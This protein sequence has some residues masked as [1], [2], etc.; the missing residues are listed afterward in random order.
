MKI[1]VS[2]HHNPHFITVTEYI[3]RAV[4]ALGHDLITFNDREHIF[5]G[6]LRKR[7]GLLQKLSV[8]A[9][10]RGLLKIA[11]RKGPDVVLVTGGHRITQSALQKLSWLKARVVLWTTDPPHS[12][13]MMLTTA[14]H[15]HHLFCQGSEYMD[16]FH[17]MGLVHAEWLPMACDPEVH[18]RVEVSSEEKLKFGSDVVFVGSYYPQRAEMLQ[19]VLRHHSALWGPGWDVLPS[20]SPLRACIRG[21]HTQ[22]DIWTKIYSASKIVL[23]MHYCGSGSS[24]PVHQASPRVF[25]AMACGAFVLTDRQ[26]DVLSL[27]KDGEHLVAFSDDVDLDRK[28]TYYLGHA[29]EREQIANAGRQ[30]VLKNHTYGHRIDRLLARIGATVSPTSP[31]PAPTSPATDLRIGA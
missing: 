2:G 30:E 14:P 17:Q 29:D 3:E 5:P 26:K 6:R 23:S 8:G 15:Y 16:I 21:A 22:P 11:A 10:N 25:E 27:F 4:R 1:L 13:D 20:A 24:F 9:I 12:S 18:R 28:I 7:I 31:F 19:G